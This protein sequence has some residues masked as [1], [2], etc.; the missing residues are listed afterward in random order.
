MSLQY[1]NRMNKLYCY[2][3]Y[4]STLEL[5]K[6]LHWTLHHFRINKEFTKFNSILW[7]YDSPSESSNLDANILCELFSIYI[8]LNEIIYSIYYFSR[9]L[10]CRIEWRSDVFDLSALILN[11][12]RRTLRKGIRRKYADGTRTV[13]KRLNRKSQYMWYVWKKKIIYHRWL[14]SCK[15]VNDYRDILVI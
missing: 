4:R 5:Y 2:G 9:T 6:Y 13:Q 15:I 1:T 3:I 10:T 11:S 12:G 7:C 14:I 8:N